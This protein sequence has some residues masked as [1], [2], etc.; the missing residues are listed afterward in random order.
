[1]GNLLHCKEQLLLA[2]AGYQGAEKQEEL[3]NVKAEWYTAERPSKFRELKQYPRKNKERLKASLC[4]KIERP[5]R[6]I[7][8]QFGLVKA[9]YKRA[10]RKAITTGNAICLGEPVSSRS[11]NKKVGEICLQSENDGRNEDL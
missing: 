10:G 2:D 9:R 11:D 8:C 3:A 4:A 1:M 7:K 6:I 5:F